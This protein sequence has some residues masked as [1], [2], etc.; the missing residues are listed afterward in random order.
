MNRRNA[1]APAPRPRESITFARRNFST[2]KAVGSFLPA[3]TTKAF[4]K[5]GFSAA[6]LIMDWPAIAGR[7]LA[8]YAAPERLKWPRAVEHAEDDE[9]GA[10]AGRRGAT[11]ILRVDS[12]RALNVQFGARQ[13][14]E[15]INA[16]FGYA[17]VAELRVVQA[18]VAAPQTRE[19]PRQPARPLTREV[20]GVADT[21]LREAL[22]RLGGEIRAGR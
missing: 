9:A 7:E 6:T 13:I 20:A 10:P 2:A 12:A 21:R 1:P 15:R 5:Y 17:A 3:L 11:V 18:P 16:Y 14:I 8:Q 4:Q 19:G 22:G